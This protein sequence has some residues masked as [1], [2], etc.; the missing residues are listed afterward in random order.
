MKKDQQLE[1][2]IAAP[3]SEPQPTGDSASAPQSPVVRAKRSKPSQ[4][5]LLIIAVAVVGIGSL[6]LLATSMRSPATPSREVSQENRVETARGGLNH[7]E[8]AKD[9]SVPAMR[10]SA[11]RWIASGPSRRA[12]TGVM[13]ELPADEDVDVWRKRVRPVLTVRCSAKETEV[14]VMTQ[15]AASIEPT[16]QHTV[17][18]SFDDGGAAAEMWEHSVDHDALFAPNA[19]GLLHQIAAAHRMSFTFSPFNAPPALVHFSVAGL[20]EQLKSA[21]KTCGW[22]R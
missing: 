7:S 3:K 10:T 8:A 5:S 9:T 19:R 11:P 18:V 17:Q 21:T 4:F 16:G 14:F 20:E 13:F 12:G 2:P 15:S 1:L 6:M 22:K